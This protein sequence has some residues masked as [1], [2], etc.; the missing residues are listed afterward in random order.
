MTAMT[1]SQEYLNEQA[2]VAQILR[3]GMARGVGSPGLADLILKSQWLKDHESRAQKAGI[4]EFVGRQSVAYQKH[5]GNAITEDMTL[6]VIE[7]G[8]DPAAFYGG[9]DVDDGTRWL[10]AEVMRAR[11]DRLEHGHEDGAA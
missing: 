10:E 6:A 1:K 11:A 9:T 4:V 3:D 2:E 5:S 7:F 8:V